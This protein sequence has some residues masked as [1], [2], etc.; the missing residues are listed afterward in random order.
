MVGEDLNSSW[1]TLDFHL[2]SFIIWLFKDRLSLCGQGFQGGWGW[3]NFIGFEW[4]N[5]FIFFPFFVRTRIRDYL[6]AKCSKNFRPILMSKSLSWYT[7]SWKYLQQIVTWDPNC[8]AET[9]YLWKQ[10]EAFLWVPPFDIQMS[11]LYPRSFPSVKKRCWRKDWP[12]SH[13]TIT[14]TKLLWD[15]VEVS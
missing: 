3:M 10:Q 11:F 13:F 7:Y 2:N 1:L 12:H 5:K 4:S 9:S 15:Y 14:Q 8:Q 6:M